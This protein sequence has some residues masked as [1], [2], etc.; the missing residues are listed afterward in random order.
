MDPE[1][2]SRAAVQWGGLQILMQQIILSRAKDSNSIFLLVFFDSCRSYDYKWNYCCYTVFFFVMTIVIVTSTIFTSW[3]QVDGKHCNSNSAEN[4][5]NL[6]QEVNKLFYIHYNG[7]R[8]WGNHAV[9]KNLKWNR[10]KSQSQWKDK[11]SPTQQHC[12]IEEIVPWA[13]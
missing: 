2:L 13:V 6:Y 10:L 3:I 5:C 11:V 7:A 1:K 4:D 12:G 9:A 8:P